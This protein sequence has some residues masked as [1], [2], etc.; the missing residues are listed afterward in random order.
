MLRVDNVIAE[1]LE[2]LGCPFEVTCLQSSSSIEQPILTSRVMVENESTVQHEPLS[3]EV[4]NKSHK[5]KKH[6][7]EKKEKKNKSHKEHRKEKRHK[8]TPYPESGEPLADPAAPDPEADKSP[9]GEGPVQKVE[10][11]E[12]QRSGSAPESG[13]IPEP[14]GQEEIQGA[15][16]VEAGAGPAQE[17]GY[18]EQEREQLRWDTINPQDCNVQFVQLVLVVQGLLDLGSGTPAWH[19]RVPGCT[20]SVFHLRP[21]ALESELESYICI[22][23]TDS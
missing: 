10:A 20:V 12:Q 21:Y 22:A 7:K 13:E 5:E 14:E 1:L 4:P 8:H 16:E 19:S 6:K 9:A 2:G 23:F 17:I 18:A 11:K 15:L 3:E